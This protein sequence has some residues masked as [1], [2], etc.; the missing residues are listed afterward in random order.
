MFIPMAWMTVMPFAF[1]TRSR[2]E[3]NREMLAQRWWQRRLDL[4]VDAQRHLEQIRSTVRLR[5]CPRR[6]WLARPRALPR[7]CPRRR[8]RDRLPA[9]AL[10]RHLCGCGRRS[11]PSRACGRGRR[12][13]PPRACAC[14][15][16]SRRRARAPTTRAPSRPWA[17]WHFCDDGTL[18][19]SPE[20]RVVDF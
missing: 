6:R 19:G 3:L 10:G 2:T 11:S 18:L 12:S 20:V 13:R 8:L 17:S 9:A 4:G 16:R 1:S 15:C 7:A 14:G 5:A